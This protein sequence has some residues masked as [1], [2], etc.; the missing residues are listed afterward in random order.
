MSSSMRV[1]ALLLV[2]AAFP[3]SL[4]QT[5]VDD[6]ETI[7]VEPWRGVVVA[8]L[9][10]QQIGEL[11]TMRE[12][13]EGAAAR[14]AAKHISEAETDLLQTLLAKES[15][16]LRK[17]AEL[18]RTNRQFHHASTTGRFTRLL[19]KA[20]RLTAVTGRARRAF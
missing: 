15:K 10:R 9:D 20:A 6:G 8:T 19:P 11:Y 4:A 13:L 14:L 18:A 17:P 2:V 5:W 3:A 1:F 12:V 7:R 16:Q